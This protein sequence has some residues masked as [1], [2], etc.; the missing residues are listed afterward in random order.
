MPTSYHSKYLKYKLKYL[1]LK[2][3]KSGASLE[4]S[5]NIFHIYTTGIANWGQFDTH[6]QN[7]ITNWNSGVRENIISKVPENF[8]IKIY[9]YDPLLVVDGSS[10]PVKMKDDK[11]TYTMGYI[12]QNLIPVDLNNDRVISSDFIEDYF[13]PEIINNPYIVLD[14]YGL[15]DYPNEIGYVIRRLNWSQTIGDPFK[16]SVL[17]FGWFGS[18]FATMLGRSNIVQISDTGVVSTFVDKMIELKN[19]GC[20]DG[21]ECYNF[22]I[23]EPSGYIEKIYT[24][25]IRQI[26]NRIK[27][28]KGGSST[29]LPYF[30]VEHIGNAVIQN[31]SKQEIINS[32]L[33][34]IWNDFTPNRIIN[35]I[36]D[37]IITV[38][39][40]I[41]TQME[42]I[43]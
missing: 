20:D 23:R 5:D 4:S 17:R 16:L 21:D 40:D 37:Y 43:D 39:I 32:I 10:G 24:K 9:H 11:K 1:T 41:I 25:T 6:G 29:P 3:Q 34:R 31:N 18:D 22:R 42:P 28:I 30:Q 35:E 14:F 36:S 38:N 15:Y 27:E 8:Q 13:N 7:L 19:R 2:N 26:E 12:N 33:N